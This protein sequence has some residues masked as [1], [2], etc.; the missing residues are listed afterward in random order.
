[1][2]GAGG[3]G[4]APM[5]SPKGGF[6]SGLTFPI[7][8]VRFCL[9]VWNQTVFVGHNHFEALRLILRVNSA[10][11]NDIRRVVAVSSQNRP[12]SSASRNVGARPSDSGARGRSGVSL[13]AGEPKRLKRKKRRER[14]HGTRSGKTPQWKVFAAI[15]LAC[16][17]AAFIAG[18][19]FNADYGSVANYY[20]FGDTDPK[21]SVQRTKELDTEFKD[22]IKREFSSQ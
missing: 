14:I 11:G 10:N 2:K 15:A 21:I 20:M 1:M 7:L 19:L 4:K 16:A 3:F 17:A 6:D 9:K 22:M 8:F 13:S 18:V 12:I 5:R